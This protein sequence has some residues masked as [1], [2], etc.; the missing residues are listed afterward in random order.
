M[1]KLVKS[2]TKKVLHKV[3]III[4]Y[5]YMAYFN[6]GEKSYSR[7][8]LQSGNVNQTLTSSG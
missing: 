1:I 7:M 6:P 2:V 3:Q 5:I 8:N 4:I